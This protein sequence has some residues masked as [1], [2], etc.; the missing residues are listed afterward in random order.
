MG[1]LPS[2]RRARA[3]VAAVR[4]A[5]TGQGARSRGEAM[6][7]QALRRADERFAATRGVRKPLRKCRTCGSTWACG[8]RGG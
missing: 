3:V 4:A 2:T 1:E 6:D 7:R 8:H 5:A